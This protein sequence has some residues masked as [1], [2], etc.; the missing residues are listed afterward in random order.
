MGVVIKSGGRRQA[1]MASKIRRSIEHAAREA[2]V[3]GARARELVKEVGGSVIDFYRRKRSVRTSELRKSIL[4]RLDRRAR[5]VSSA[6]RRYD[7]S[8]RRR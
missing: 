4:R 2:G 5:S 6:W 1:F 8:R 3:G 7:R